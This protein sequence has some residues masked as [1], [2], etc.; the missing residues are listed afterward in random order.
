MR[1]AAHALLILALSLAALPAAAAE[2]TLDSVYAKEPPWG[3]M[4]NRVDWS[5]N[6][7]YFL[8]IRR[9]QDPSEALPVMM[10]DVANGTSRVWL[11]PSAFGSGAG[12]PQIASWSPGGDRVALLARG[13]LYWSTVA[14]PRPHAI[15][16][17]V[18]EAQWSPR[19]DAIAYSHDADLYVAM[20]APRERIRRIT[21]GGVPDDVLNGTLDWVYPEELGIEHGFRWSPDGTLVAYLTMDERRVTDF[22]IVDFLTTNNGVDFERY[23]LAGEA[24]PRV[25]LRVADLRTD[26]T[27]LV[28]D[29]GARD[30][31]VAAFDW[32]RGSNRLEAEILDRAQRTL[33]I[34]AWSAPRG[35]PALIYYQTSRSWVDVQ[36]LPHWLDDGR[37]VWLLDRHRTAGLYLRG[38]DGSMRQLTSNFRVRSLDGV[39]PDGTIYFTAAYP[40]RRESS[41]LELRLHDASASLRNLTPT[42]GWHATTLSPRFDRFVDLY[43][44]LNDPPRSDLVSIASLATKTLAPENAALK[45][46]LLPT[47]MLEVPSA[48]G[49]LDAVLLEPPGFTP[50]KKYPVVVFV[51][52]GPDA[53]TTADTFNYSD[54]LYHQPLAREGIIVFSIDGPASQVDDDEHVRLLLHD[55][56][57]GSLLGQEIGAR[58]LATLPYVDASRIGMWGWSFGGYETCYALTHSH[59]FKAGAAVAPVTDW[60]LYDTI[61]T[62]R[63]MGLPQKNARAYDG[64][65]VLNAAGHLNGPLLIQHGTSDDNVHMANTMQLVQRFI[66]ARES[67]VLFYPY[68]RKTHS[69]AGLAQRRSVFEHMLDFWKTY[70]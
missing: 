58:Y 2:I 39:T 65:S 17:G 24:N 47:Q 59:L 44:R 43:G 37:S 7:K 28:Y 5:P 20:L 51:Y 56:G 25:T 63:Y 14:D 33:R 49:P 12:T 50:S 67:R 66:L 54:A 57:P 53:P 23:P 22:P 6:G 13:R 30:E 19:G 40:T 36:P 46:E 4:V 16:N 21:Q 29:A 10:Y 69:I 68:P 31:Y 55:F 70:L 52:G 38:R 3:R 8:F 42:P 18:D 62:E 32:I 27:R 60:H 64:S 15:A 1:S 48:Y 41:L 9:S 26:S 45:A 35:N 34:D 11:A 61:Y